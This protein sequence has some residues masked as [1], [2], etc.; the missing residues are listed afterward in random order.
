MIK[1]LHLL[2]IKDI[3]STLSKLKL[4]KSSEIKEPQEL[5]I[6][7]IFLTFFVLKLDISKDIK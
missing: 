4:V 1:E 5:N 6:P 2:N 3:S 7:Y